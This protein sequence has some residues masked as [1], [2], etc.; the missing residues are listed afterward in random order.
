MT[1]TSCNCFICAKEFNEDDLR[2]VVL[3]K[4]NITHF[5]VCQACF[6]SCDPSEDYSEVRNIVNS[7]LKFAEIK[8]L[9]IE[10]QDILNSRN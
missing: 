5:K 9:F 7:Y 3:S 4:I 2:S 1:K 6:D 10:V 8:N